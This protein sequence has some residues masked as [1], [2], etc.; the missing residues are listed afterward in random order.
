MIEVITNVN[1]F[2]NGL[3]WGWPALVLLGFVGVLMTCMTKFFQISH[4]GHWMKHTIGAIFGDKHVT[5][6]TQDHS[7]SQFQ[8]LCTALA[9]TVG[10]GNIV[11]VAGAIA[12][13]GPGAVFWMWL[14]AFFGM[15][16]NYSENVLGILYRRK[17]TKGEWAGGAMYYLRDGLGS[18]KGCKTIGV[19]LAALFSCFC[20]LASFGIGNMSQVNSMVTNVYTAFHIP[21][22]VTGIILFVAVAAVVLGGLKRIASITEKIVPFMVIIYLL[23][24]LVIIIMHAGTIPAVFASIFQ[25]AFALKS[26]AGGVVGAGIAMAMQMGFKRGVFSNE[27]GLG[28]SVMVHS[29]SNVKEP[30][31]QGM[32]GIFEVFADTIVVCTLTALTILSSGAIDLTTGA[33]TEAAEAVGS[34]S[35]MSYAFE[36]TFGRPGAWFIAIAILLFAYSTVLGW[37]HYGSTACQY[38]FGE[39]SVTVYRIIFV[40]IVLAGSVMEAQLA[41]DISDTFNGMMMIPNLIGVL[42][43]SPVVMKCTKNYVD[44]RIRGKKVK[45]ML[46]MFEDI[47]AEQERSLSEDD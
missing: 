28:S 23:G 32:W 42:V 40:I 9:A 35:L 10:T 41:W 36:Q 46:S 33:M 12:V 8:S 21:Q 37:S 16:T 7:I 29:S 14:I 17:N 47:Q 26:A 19:V 11:G 30:V 3:V 27:A 31:R 38:L 6:H 43:L 13:G 18:K 25:G 44:R 15:M 34:S 45:P 2:V 20:L 24:T 1:S 4:F 5:K 39:K 22:I